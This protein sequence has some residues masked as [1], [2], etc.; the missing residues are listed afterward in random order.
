[1]TEDRRQRSDDRRQRSDDRRQRSDDRRQRSDDRGQMT[2]DRGR[3]T[4]VGWQKTGDR[5]RSQITEYRMRRRTRV[6]FG[7]LLL[8][9]DG[10][11]V[12][13]H[14]AFNAINP[15]ELLRII[16]FSNQPNNQ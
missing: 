10:G 8:K 4:E 15:T 7:C 16:S 14:V 2:E 5:G 3:K 12:G 13:R 6:S 9:N 11:Q 1:M